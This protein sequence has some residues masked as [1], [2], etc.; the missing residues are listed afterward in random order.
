MADRW[1]RKPALFWCLATASLGNLIMFVAGLGYSKGALAV[2]FA[3][4]V[5][6]G[7]GVGGVDSVVPIYS[8]ELSDE[9]ARGKAM[10]LEFQANVFGLNMA[11]AINLGLTVAL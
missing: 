8:S 1:G 11:F 3:G 5:V 7:L 10:S 2:M 4:R 9:G 6:M